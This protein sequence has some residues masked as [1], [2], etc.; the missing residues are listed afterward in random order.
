MQIQLPMRIAVVF[1]IM[2][3]G[4][5]RVSWV[6]LVA[7]RI[8]VEEEEKQRRKRKETLYKR[9]GC[10]PGGSLIGIMRKK[11]QTSPKSTPS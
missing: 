5:M 9:K 3:G 4:V 7:R 8:K 6:K 2:D 1:I 11:Y 10:Y